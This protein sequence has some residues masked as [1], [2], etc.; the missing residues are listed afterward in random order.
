MEQLYQWVTQYIIMWGYSAIFIGI[1]L[2]NANIPIPSE[3]VLAFAGYL[4]YED[5]LDFTL[6]V[7][8][9][10]GGGLAGSVLSYL[11]GYYGGPAFA[12]KYGR[13]VLLSES[14]L[15]LAEKWYARYGAAVTLFGR[16]V[17]LV[18]T[19]ISLPAGFARMD[20]GKFLL[21]TFLGTVPW[22]VALIYAGMLLGENWQAIRELGHT[23]GLAVMALLAV[24]AV[25]W[26]VKATGRAKP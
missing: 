17:P 13:Y 21:Y 7:A 2:G 11:A 23:A 22:T 9:G 10:I 15:I 24:V 5:R 12:V 8:T 6:A 25:F 3:V 20:F 18:R 4:V 1:L 16:L 19:F 14:K 26:A